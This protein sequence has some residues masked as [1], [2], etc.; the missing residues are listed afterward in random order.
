MN[1]AAG[2]G[3][4][5]AGQGPAKTPTY[6]SLAFGTVRILLRAGELLKGAGLDVLVVPR[7]TKGC[8]VLLLV[9][10]HLTNAAL[11]ALSERGIRPQ[12]VMLYTPSQEISRER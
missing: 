8:G 1:Q 5:S 2:T 3:G 11:S 10:Q 6:C 12:R 7:R 4:V 9:E